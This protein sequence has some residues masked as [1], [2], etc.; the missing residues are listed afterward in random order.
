MHLFFCT[1]VL[2][3]AAM[4]TKY[5]R[6]ILKTFWGCFLK[7]KAIKTSLW[8]SSSINKPKIIHQSD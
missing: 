3:N 4:E 8:F 7:D 1:S 2:D 6:Q 5:L